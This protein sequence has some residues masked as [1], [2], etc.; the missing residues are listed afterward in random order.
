MLIIWL[1]S[2][3]C[4]ACYRLV[5]ST[6]LSQLKK[7]FLTFIMSTVN[8]SN[9]ETDLSENLLPNLSA[10]FLEKLFSHKKFQSCFSK[11]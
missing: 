1:C 9:T 5:L 7:T 4:S 6:C 8:Y 2:M 3:E 11:M 10:M